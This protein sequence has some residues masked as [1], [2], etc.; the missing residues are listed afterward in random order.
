[1]AKKYS[2]PLSGGGIMRYGDEYASKFMMNPGTVVLIVVVI[3]FVI[4]ILNMVGVR[5]FGIV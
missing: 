1:M 4:V 2:M 5:L 3:I